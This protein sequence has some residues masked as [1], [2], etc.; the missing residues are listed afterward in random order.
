[1]HLSLL[2]LIDREE[3]RKA[4]I[5]TFVWLLKEKREFLFV[6]MTRTHTKK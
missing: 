6:K 2:S 4:V 3:R 5:F 1:M